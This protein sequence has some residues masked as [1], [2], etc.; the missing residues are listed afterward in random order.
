M[1]RL[2][3][4]IPTNWTL[5][6]SL[7]ALAMHNNTI[8]GTVGAGGKGGGGSAGRGGP[9]PRAVLARAATM[10]AAWG[11][12]ASEAW[13][14]IG[15]SHAERMHMHRGAVR[16]GAYAYTFAPPQPCRAPPPAMRAAGT[17]PAWPNPGLSVTVSPGNDGLCGSVPT[18]PK[19]FYFALIDGAPVLKPLTAL[20][21]CPEEGGSGLDTG[22]IV[23]GVV[24][25]VA[26]L[27]ECGRRPRGV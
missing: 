11:G 26:G 6:A 2:T 22:A 24:G 20:P 12:G 13:T 18:M 16:C 3:G 5:P 14:G 19:F 7:L 21:P 23:G 9:K 1:N 10:A 25:G 17:L 15:C 4:G 27:G 8:E